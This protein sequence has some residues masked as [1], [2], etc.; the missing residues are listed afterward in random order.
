[1]F[2]SGTHRRSNCYGSPGGNPGT[3]NTLASGLRVAGDNTLL[4]SGV[5]SS[6][7]AGV[8]LFTFD[9]TNAANAARTLTLN[10]SVTGDQLA[11][12]STGTSAQSNG[13][14]CRTK[15]LAAAASS[16]MPLPADQI[17]G[18][19]FSAEDCFSAIAAS[20]GQQLSSAQTASANDQSSL[21]TA[22]TNRQQ[23]IG[24]SLDREATNITTYERGYQANAQVVSIL[25][26]A[27]W[28]DF[29]QS[30]HLR[31]APVEPHWS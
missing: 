10:S 9:T 24:V 17:S 21:T 18:Q 15:P 26:P 11:L 5:T 14:N 29:H 25:N 13:A 16:S 6:G 28:D 2:E 7:A 30:C 1:M 19:P 27:Y 8:P 22:Q 12:A 31:K 3:L 23:Q 4:T 20:V